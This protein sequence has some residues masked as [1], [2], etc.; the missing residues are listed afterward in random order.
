MLPESKGTEWGYNLSSRN[1]VTGVFSG[2]TSRLKISFIQ[3]FG[4]IATSHVFGFG[5]IC[6]CV[7]I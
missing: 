7:Y 1:T 4:L 5:H 6:L 2:Q 3:G